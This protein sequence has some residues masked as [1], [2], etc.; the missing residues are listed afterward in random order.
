MDELDGD[1]GLLRDRNGNQCIRDTVQFI[2]FNEYK[3]GEKLAQA[4]LEEIPNQ[5]RDYYKYLNLSPED[6]DD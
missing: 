1:D 4:V 2:L 5:I 3:N 6:L